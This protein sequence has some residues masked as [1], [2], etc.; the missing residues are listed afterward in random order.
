MNI[1][2]LSQTVRFLRKQSGL[3]QRQLAE[4]A[5]VSKTVVFDVEKGKQTVQL[6]S[7]LKILTILNVKMI[8]ETPIKQHGEENEKS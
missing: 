5:G 8:L 4:L 7:I 2:E 1:P 3:T 6:D